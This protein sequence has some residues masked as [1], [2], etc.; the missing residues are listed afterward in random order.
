MNDSDFDKKIKKDREGDVLCVNSVN[1]VNF[2]NNKITNLTNLTNLTYNNTYSTKFKG[3]NENILYEILLME[4]QKSVW[5]KSHICEKCKISENVLNVCLN[6]LVKKNYLT[7]E[8]QSG[9]KIHILTS[10]GLEYI[11]N[12]IKIFEDLNYNKERLLEK[13]SEYNINLTYKSYLH[14]LESDNKIS[15]DELK[16]KKEFEFDIGQFEYYSPEIY[17]ELVKKPQDHKIYIKKALHELDYK[18]VSVPRFTNF[19]DTPQ[20]NIMELRSTHVD[21]LLKIR[22]ELENRSENVDVF[23][24][25]VTKEC[26]SCG[27]YIV[28]HI[29]DRCTDIDKI[30]K[31]KCN[32]CGSNNRF[33]LIKQTTKDIIKLKIKELMQDVEHKH[34]SKTTY[35]E[36][37]GDL[38]KQKINKK[39]F[40]GAK[41][42]LLGYFQI[43]EEGSKEK[44][45]K[46]VFN[47]ENISFLD[48]DY[49]E[50]LLSDDEVNNFKKELESNNNLLED[51]RLNLFERLKGVCEYT[52]AAQISLI[53]QQCRSSVFS[54]KDIDFSHIAIIGDSG[55]GKS[56][57]IKSATSIEP[58]T[59]VVAGKDLS[60]AGL[61]G[62]VKK[63]EF[64]GDYFIMPGALV[65]CN[66]GRLV[67]DE[68]NKM[69]DELQGGLLDPM[70]S[71]KVTISKA[72]VG[73]ALA[74]T[75]TVW[76]GNPKKE[77][78]SEAPTNTQLNFT[79]TMYKRFDLLFC[80]R[81]KHDLIKDK[82]IVKAISTRFRRSE[83]EQTELKVY[84]DKFITKYLFYVRNN[85]NPELTESG[86]KYFTEKVVLLKNNGYN[87]SN[88]YFVTIL[89][90]SSWF[91]KFRQSNLIEVE[92]ID[93][94]LK[95]HGVSLRSQEWGV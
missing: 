71:G 83:P 23:Y 47:V 87:L 43:R 33:K 24:E 86:E 3:N 39:L 13:K 25:K 92:D 57:L 48:D 37:V 14:L 65:R 49:Q 2:V 29:S 21:K 44:K 12:Q 46:Y 78:F 56:E 22:C 30:L 89:K 73:T 18:V 4:Q 80:L 60:E 95:L 20:L 6:R 76:L 74:N 69:A 7:I 77:K 88:R 68:C 15:F 75:N 84:D 17:A 59:E 45:L 55:L 53:L 58:R 5:S 42:E 67:I 36:L 94:A 66:D 10:D 82:M 90:I 51:F 79:D 16:T 62:T 63:D 35:A 93:N 11:E 9:Y 26:K 19:K 8:N 61:K 72:A 31:G 40:L 54:K 91:S 70:T 64:T 38:C 27:N 85:F 52:K 1:S 50:K 32:S 81:D 34:Q 28:E 41:L